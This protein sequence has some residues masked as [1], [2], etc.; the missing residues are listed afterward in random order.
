MKVL[1]DT[2]VVL[3]LLLA[4]APFASVA[5]ALTARVE[6]QQIEGYLCATSLTTIHYLV[7]KTAGQKTAIQAIHTLLQLF[8]IAPVNQLVLAKAAVSGFRDFEDAVLHESG[9]QCNAQILVTRNPKDFRLSQL[10]IQS[11]QELEAFLRLQAQ[12]NPS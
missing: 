3:D 1:F 12:K 10:L 7:A 6:Q 5:A 4:R 2:N 11:P 9:C 8:K